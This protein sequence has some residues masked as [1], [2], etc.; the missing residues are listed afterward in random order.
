MHNVSNI[1]NLEGELKLKTEIQNNESN[2][3]AIVI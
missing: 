2:K 1:L 3:L